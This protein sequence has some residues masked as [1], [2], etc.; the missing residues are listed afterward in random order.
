MSI[1]EIQRKFRRS[2]RQSI[3]GTIRIRLFE[4]LL[5]KLFQNRFIRNMGWLSAAEL[6]GRISRL[7]TVI[8]LARFLDPHAYGL[9]AIVITVN[10]FALVFSMRSGIGS[11]LIQAGEAELE[12]LLETA[13]WMNWIVGIS[14]CLLQC[15]AAFPVAY[16]YKDSAII[17]PICLSASVYL[18]LPLYGVQLSLIYRENRLNV[19][20]LCNALHAIVSN[21]LSI[22]LAILG[23]GMWAIVLPLILV[24]PVWVI[25][26]RRNHAWRS[27]HKFTLKG[28]QTIAGFSLNI[29]G[30]ELLTKLRGNLDYLLVGLFLGVDTLGIYYFAFSAGLGTSIS[31]INAFTWSLFPHLCEAREDRQEMQKRYLNGL[32][33]SAFLFVPLIALQSGLAPFYVPIVYGEKWISAIPILILICLSALPRP[34]AESASVLLQ[35]TD[36]TR[37]NLHWNLLF[38]IAFLIALFPAAKTSILGVAVTVLVTHL[39]ALPLFTAWASRRTFSPH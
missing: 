6:V 9:A 11:K 16:F 33:T 28:W 36:R 15:L 17:L 24:Y 12:S 38:T 37:E 31:V 5:Q 23:F 22:I 8:L 7:I 34:F 14:L 3:C 2:I 10:E 30:V 13:Y 29:L 21:G 1:S 4:T 20:A 25:I 26:G 27:S 32:K 18:M 35:A 39:V 19:V